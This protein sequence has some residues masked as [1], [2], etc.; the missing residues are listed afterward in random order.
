MQEIPHYLYTGRRPL[1][2]SECPFT[3]I[4]IIFFFFMPYT[5]GAPAI[6]PSLCTP[7]S[8]GRRRLWFYHLD[9]FMSA[10][11]PAVSLC[12]ADA[13][14]N[15]EAQLDSPQQGHLGASVGGRNNAR[16]AFIVKTRRDGLMRIQVPNASLTFSVMSSAARSPHCRE[17]ALPVL[18]DLLH[19]MSVVQLIDSVS[20]FTTEMHPLA[21]MPHS[22]S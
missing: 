2:M 11:A 21:R 8:L 15:M 7:V 5:V 20:R 18:Q 22:L 12:G 9:S 19:F 13:G 6:K 3:I 1:T 10:D 4:I 16:Q 14:R 17:R